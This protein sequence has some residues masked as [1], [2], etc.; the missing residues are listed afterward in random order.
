MKCKLKRL[1]FVVQSILSTNPT[2]YMFLYKL[3]GKNNR[4]LVNS[5]TQIVIEGFPRSGN[6]FSVVALEWAQDRKL[7]IAHH[8]HAATQIIWAVNNNIPAVALIRKPVDAVAS[9][10]IREPCITIGAGLREYIRFYQA[11]LPYKKDLLVVE[12][13][14]V[15]SDYGESI[16][17]MNEKFSTDFS[18][19]EHNSENVKKVF[20]LVQQY[21][22]EESTSNTLDEK[23]VARPSVDRKLQAESFKNIIHGSEYSVLLARANELYNELLE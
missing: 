8:L 7:N 16:M 19:F 10:V 21:S 18:F 17:K 13:E 6:T 3:F 9:L 14:Q 4:L 5:D 11:I 15:I 12:F 23:K 2:I 20:E 22:I 1:L